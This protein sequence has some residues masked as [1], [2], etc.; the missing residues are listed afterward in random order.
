[1]E[2]KIDARDQNPVHEEYHQASVSVAASEISRAT[3]ES[4]G[5][6]NLQLL[7]LLLTGD[8]EARPKIEREYQQ[9]L[10]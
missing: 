7:L 3:T 8:S 1:M 6:F 9:S 2:V 4:P 5:D 10:F